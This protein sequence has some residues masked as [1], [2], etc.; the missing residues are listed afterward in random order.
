M[1]PQPTDPTK[2]VGPADPNPWCRERALNLHA[3]DAIAF[4]QVL[5]KMPEQDAA[6]LRYKRD[7]LE[8]SEIGTRVRGSR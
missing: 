5:A 8:S 4:E 2:S 7:G 3:D 1:Q 6:L